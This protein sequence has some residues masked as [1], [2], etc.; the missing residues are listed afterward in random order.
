MMR[1]LLIVPRISPQ[2]G[3]PSI[4]LP[5]LARCLASHGIDTTILTTTA[6]SP[7]VPDVPRSQPVVRDGVTYL[8]H[9]VLAIGGRYGWSP[10]LWT[11][12]HRTV[13]AYDIVHIHWLYDFVCIAAARAAL[14]A[15]VP[16]V[17]QPNG[18]LDPHLSKK[19]A[20]LKRLYLATV[21]QPLLTRAAALVFTSEQERAQALYR[22]GRP[23]WILPVGLD[24]ST[25]TRLPPRG[26]F[27]AAFPAVDGP[28]LLFVGRLSRQ[29]GL[30]LLLGAFARV[31]REREDLS[32][33][34]AGPDPDGY[35]AHLRT[36]S[37]TLNI[38]RRVVLTGLLTHEMKLAAFVDAKL[39]VLPSYA[40]NFGAVTTEAL[41]CGL[42]VVISDQVN[43]HREMAAAGVATVVQC[44]IDSVASGITAALADSSLRARIATLG[45]ALVHAHYTWDTIAPACIDKYAETIAGA[46]RP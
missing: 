34:L 20:L 15:G 27:R 22:P 8:H 3:G 1:V 29:K 12:L 33:V 25:F 40:E 4:A 2:S 46:A 39:F 21:G 28:F 17:V 36:L 32:L 11:A 5:G 10:A 23:E 19:N 42:P 41:A 24:A 14:A 35:G 26:T 30:D 7:D 38:Q 37:E 45:P 43:I 13:A 18:S 44:S 16:Y 9:P 31:A 6:G